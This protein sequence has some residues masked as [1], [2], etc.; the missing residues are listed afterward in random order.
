MRYFL[1]T[2]F[3][4]DGFTIKLISLAIVSEDSRELY[5]ESANFDWGS[6]TKWLI[7]NVKPHL[8]GG[9]SCLFEDE[10]KQR[11]LDFVSPSK[12]G[13]PEFWGYYANYDWVLL[14]QLFGKMIDIPKDWPMYIN[15]IKSFQKV[16]NPKLKFKNYF[17]DK[18]FALN[19]ANN[20][21]GYYYQ[22]F[23]KEKDNE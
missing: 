15:D 5:L 10:I 7:D 20:I 19:D 12:Y 8:V 16:L 22:L 21:K 2:E 9:K 13:K 3:L 17:V 4:E 6:A 11:I 23:N 14:C 1:D 18:H